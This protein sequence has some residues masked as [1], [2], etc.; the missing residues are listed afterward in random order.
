MDDDEGEVLIGIRPKSSPLPRRRSSVSDE[1][2]EPEPPL[3]GSRR[4]SFAD[5]KGLSLVQ[6][7]EFDCWDV[8]KLPGYDSTES[9]GKDAEEYF[10]SPLN[11]SLTLSTEELFIKVREQKMELESIKL[12]PGTTILKGMIRVLNISFN[13]AVYIRTTLDSWSTH[14]DLL[15]EYIPSSSDSLTD[16]FSFKLTLVPPFGEQGARV[17]FCLRYETPVG[18]FWTNNNN[19]NYVLFCHQR[20]KERKEKTQ[21][22]NV[23]RKSCLKAVSQNFS[24][25]ENI[26]AMEA[27]SQE[28]ISTDVSKHG[29][30]VDMKAKQISDGQSVKSEEDGQKLLAENRRNCSRRNRRRAARLAR[31]R[32]LFAQRGGGANG[33]ERDESPP[34][35]NRATQEETLKEKQSDMQ[36]FSEAISKLEGSPLV[37]ES[38]SE[39]VCDVPNDTSPAHDLTSNSE[40]GKSESINLADSATLTGGESAADIPDNSLHSND[41]PAA[42]EYQHINKSVSKAEESSQKQGMSHDCTTNIA[43]EPADSVVSAMSTESLVSKSDSFT[44][45]TVVAPLYHQVSGKVG[46]ES[47]SVG[48]WGNPVQATLNVGDLSHAERR[49]TSC[50]V[51]TGA[52]K[53]QAHV[54]KTEKSKQESLD[55]TLNNPP[56]EEEEKNDVPNHAETQ[57]THSGDTVIHPHT[58]N[59]INTELSNPQKPTESLHFQ[60]EAQED[61]LTHDLRSQTTAETAQ[62]QLLEHARTQTKTNLDDTGAQSETEEVVAS[63]ETSFIPLNSYKCV[64]ESNKDI[65][66]DVCG[67]ITESTNNGMSEE[68]KLPE[69]LHELNP[70]HINNSYTQETE[71]SCVSCFGILEET[72]VTPQMSL[73][74]HKETNDV[75]KE[76]KEKMKSNYHTC[77]DTFV[78]LKDED[79]LKDEEIIVSEEMEAAVLKRENICLADTAEVKN[80]EMMVE[81]EEKNILTDEEESVAISSKAEDA[82]EVEEDRGQQLDDTGNE[83][84]LENRDITETDNE[85]KE[86][87]VMKITGAR[88]KENEAEDADASG[89]KHRIGEEQIVEIVAGKDDEAFEKELEYVKAKKTAG[90]EELVEENEVDKREEQDETE[91][92]KEELFAEI[93]E[94]SVERIN[95]QGEEEIEGEEEIDVDLNDDGVEWESHVKPREENP[96]YKEEIPVDETSRI[97]DAELESITKG[98]SEKRL[99]K[100]QNKDDD[101]LSALDYVQDKR[102]TDKENTGEGQNVQIPTEMDLYEEGAFQSNEN[103][104]HDLLKAVRDELESAAAEGGSSFLANEPESDQLSHNSASESDS[105]DEVELY[106]HCLR[107]VHTGAQA[108]K[109]RNKETSFSGGKKP[110]VSRNK[111]LSTP[112]PSISESL[113][114]EPNL[115]CLQDN[116]EEMETAD[117]QPTA[118]ALPPLSQ[119]RESINRNVSWWKETF[120]CSNISK[121]LLCTTLLVVFAVVAFHY[122]FLACFG[123]YVISVIWLCCQGERQPAKNNNRIG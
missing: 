64:D 73:E 60:G 52:H 65:T 28:N 110:S 119:E 91:L 109:D 32:D 5:S 81:E 63:P 43:A 31:V 55:A 106:M 6:V 25:V 68:D 86:E 107:A 80:W 44:F 101:G 76:N 2:S 93:E 72:D 38:C 10:L 3:S 33:T 83:T 4:V 94:V 57:K 11:F 123:L 35:A 122:D 7:K 75:E 92:E 84:A 95:V 99:D 45:G 66:N 39:P 115:S 118:A 117:F 22:E 37:S 89:D 1:D 23:N 12:L 50:T 112:M 69:A 87:M 46:S 121:T 20:V 90:E 85:K 108:Q 98:D 111:M 71:N 19:K 79:T 102:V 26:S 14:F 53:V 97:V 105:D 29:E 21:L 104:T 116:H 58:V 17:D 51:Q 59:A 56:V 40:P 114:E 74:N 27:S 47:Q 113:D 70:N 18:T 62:A 100:I 30:K 49:D 61:N 96:D 120:S 41:D 9:E 24:T 82:E 48:D 42:A 78:E 16:C 34:E 15:A 67:T 13:K 8:P 88:A 103:V 54:V 77:V 36:S